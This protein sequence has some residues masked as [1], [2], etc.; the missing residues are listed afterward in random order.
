M[1]APPPRGPIGGGIGG[2]GGFG[3]PGPIPGALG[4][5]IWVALPA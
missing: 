4:E 2:P 5:N 1:V 3:P